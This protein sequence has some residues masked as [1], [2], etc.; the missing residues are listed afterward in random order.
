MTWVLKE[1][2]LIELSSHPERKAWLE[3]KAYDVFHD[4]WEKLSPEHREKTRIGALGFQPMV[5]TDSIQAWMFPIE[6]HP[7]ILGFKNRIQLLDKNG[8]V[9]F[10]GPWGEAPLE[11]IKEQVE[12]FIWLPYRHGSA[13]EKLDWKTRLLGMFRY[14]KNRNRKKLG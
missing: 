8:K 14:F 1:E 6:G 9:F 2:V 3:E 12:F 11:M 13:P 10:D 5:G 7:K 4:L